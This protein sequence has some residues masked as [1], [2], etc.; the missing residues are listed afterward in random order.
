MQGT[1]VTRP[2]ATLAVLAACAL[3]AYA[4]QAAG[5]ARIQKTWNGGPRAATSA[6]VASPQP[7]PQPQRNYDNRTTQWQPER[8]SSYAN[9]AP[10]AIQVHE[11]PNYQFTQVAPRSLW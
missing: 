8:S 10:P 7:R 2:L 11:K 1:S 6:P 5:P 9:P 4:T 3:G